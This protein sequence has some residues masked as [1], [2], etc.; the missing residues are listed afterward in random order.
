MKNNI[1]K[2]KI[3]KGDKFYIASGIGL[4]VVTQGKNLDELEKNIVEALE[5]HL[6]GNKVSSIKSAKR[7]SILVNFELPVT[8]CLG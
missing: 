6:M 3:S 7:S 8:L 1:F 2:F 4:P 5:L